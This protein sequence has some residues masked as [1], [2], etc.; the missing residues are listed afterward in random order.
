METFMPELATAKFFAFQLGKT[1]TAGI[2]GE[3]TLSTICRQVFILKIVQAL[4][5]A[6]FA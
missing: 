6:L 4:S 5:Q 3:E 2:A 1:L